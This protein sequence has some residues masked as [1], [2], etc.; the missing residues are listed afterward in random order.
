[1]I[2]STL[3]LTIPVPVAKGT[4]K[5]DSCD[6]IS[7][8]FTTEWN[9]KVVKASQYQTKPDLSDARSVA[10][11]SLSNE[12]SDLE[13]AIQGDMS[14][15]VPCDIERTYMSSDSEMSMEDSGELTDSFDD[16]RTMNYA[17]VDEND[18]DELMRFGIDERGGKPKPVHGILIEHRGQPSD[19]NCSYTDE[20]KL[21]DAAQDYTGNIGAPRSRLEQIRSLKHCI[22]DDTRSDGDVSSQTSNQT[23]MS[24]SCSSDG[25]TIVMYEGPRFFNRMLDVGEIET[26]PDSDGDGGDIETLDSGYESDYE[27]RSLFCGEVVT[28]DDNDDN[29][30]RSFDETLLE[31]ETDVWRTVAGKEDNFIDGTATMPEFNTVSDNALEVSFNEDNFIDGT[32]TM[33]EF[34]TVSD[35]AQKVSFNVDTFEF[36]CYERVEA[37]TIDVPCMIKRLESIIKMSDKNTEFPIACDKPNSDKRSRSTGDTGRRNGTRKKFSRFKKFKRII[38]S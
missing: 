26:L 36:D 27:T 14:G 29:S 24:R 7:Y 16:L 38:K 6:P 10:S 37:P 1:M 8:R 4:C 31:G 23:D 15:V 19:G 2:T 13:N 5:I 35:N 22:N 3:P 21:P 20:E 28:L 18:F 9:E 32:A 17:T 25:S 30:W 11:D 33:P 34:N 12:I